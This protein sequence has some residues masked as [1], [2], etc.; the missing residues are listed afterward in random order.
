MSKSQAR[1]HFL[2]L[3]R[4]SPTQSYFYGLMLT[5]C[6]ADAKLKVSSSITFQL[7]WHSVELPRL[8][9]LSHYIYYVVVLKKQ[10]QEQQ[11]AAQPK[12]W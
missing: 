4:T 8:C 12:S 11:W 7:G 1:S 9:K 6:S 10:N 3:F 5:M 2:G